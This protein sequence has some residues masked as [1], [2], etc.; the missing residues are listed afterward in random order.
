MLVAC[1]E[2]AVSVDSVVKVD[3]TRSRD[4][5]RPNGPDVK[6]LIVRDSGR[7]TK[8]G[9]R[10]LFPDALYAT[11]AYKTSS[12]SVA[13]YALIHKRPIVGCLPFVAGR[14]WR[15]GRRGARR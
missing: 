11:S 8:P 9:R 4:E 14:G 1:C 13:D 2:D 7:S 6:Q 12:K 10:Y 3:E 15:P 5:K